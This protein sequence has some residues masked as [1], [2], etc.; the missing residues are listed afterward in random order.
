MGKREL[1]LIVVFVVLGATVYQF[2]APPAA[3]GERGFSLSRLFDGV[4]RELR[5]SRASAEAVQRVSSEVA[6]E[7]SELRVVISSGAITITGE[8]RAT[9]ESELTARSNGFDDNEARRLA[10]EVVLTFE[11]AGAILFARVSFPGPGRQTARLALKIPRRLNVRIEGNSGRLEISNVSGVELGLA[12]GE[13]ILRNIE[14]RAVVSHRGGD[15]TITDVGSLKLTTRGSDVRLERVRGELTANTQAGELKGTSL[16]GPIELDASA[17]DITIDG[18]DKTT[19]MMRVNAVA[20]SVALRGLRTECRIDLRNTDLDLTIDKAA[21][22]AV[23]SDGDEP[24]DITAPP[25]GFK[26][27][28]IARDGRISSTPDDLF[29]RWRLQRVTAEPQTEQRVNG[30]VQG[31]GPTLTVRTQRGDITFRAREGT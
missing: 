4:R 16:L 26:L 2:T 31:G 23:Y 15:L 24:V 20:G 29:D 8:D 7:V 19:G 6:P 5:G 13:T 28:A 3:P 30:E 25:G 21:P 14:R 22:I 17:T 1:I 10:S 9:V 18:M 27:D 11:K 12:R